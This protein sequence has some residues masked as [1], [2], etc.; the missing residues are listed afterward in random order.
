MYKRLTILAL[1]ALLMAAPAAFAQNEATD[2]AA[3]ADEPQAEEAAENQEEMQDG[4]DL[5]V[6]V[7][8]PLAPPRM[9]RT[10]PGL[11]GVLGTNY[12]Y[13]P[14]AVV[15]E[16]QAMAFVKAYADLVED[17]VEELP[18]ALEVAEGK[19][20]GGSDQL[21]RLE[22]GV[23]RRFITDI[24]NPAAGAVTTAEIPVMIAQPRPG[25]SG[26]NVLFMDGHVELVQWGEFP[27]TREFISALMELDPPEYAEEQ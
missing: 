11:R 27:M 7:E 1:I 14:Y 23:H 12:W 3:E 17:G 10:A 6:A 20:A 8:D 13:L 15:N 16:E 22:S 26:A 19:G 25:A 18:D 4:E 5:S 2:D 24:N 9:P 21:Y